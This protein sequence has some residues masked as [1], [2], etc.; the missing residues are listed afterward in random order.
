VELRSE[1]GTIRDFPQNLLF[2]KI[3]S[4]LCHSID[5]IRLI[6]YAISSPKEFLRGTAKD[7]VVYISNDAA[8]ALSA[9]LQVRQPTRERKIFLVEKGTHKGK[10]ISVR[11]IQKRIE[12]YSKQSG[13]S[14]SCHNLRHNADIRIM[15][16]WH[17]A[18]GALLTLVQLK[19][20][21]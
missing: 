9:Y 4:K 1:S 2:I 6:F 16:T 19:S 14:I 13:V 7:R 18:C 20:T 17:F 11:G 21:K 5:K 10:P 8:A 3:Q 12:Y 15:P